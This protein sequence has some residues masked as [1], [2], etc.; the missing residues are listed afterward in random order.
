MPAEICPRC[1]SPVRRIAGEG[2]CT[3][4]AGQMSLPELRSKPR[5]G[6]GEESQS[7]V[8]GSLRRLGRYELLEEIARGGMGVVYRACDTNLNRVVALKLMLAGQFAGE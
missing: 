1:G 6:V 2:V 3:R 7:G 4:C 5:A 8:A